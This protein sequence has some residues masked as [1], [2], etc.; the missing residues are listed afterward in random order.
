[1]KGHI[2][3]LDGTILDSIGLWREIDIRYMKQHGIEYRREYSDI[4][5]TLT[6]DECATYFKH[7]LGVPLSEEE[8]K[9]D[10]LD[11][12]YDAYANTLQLKPYAL[13]YV[14]KCAKNGSCILAT[15]CQKKSALAA[16]KRLNL[17]DYFENIVTT[18]DVGKNKEYPDIYLE[19]AKQ[20]DLKPKECL[21]YEDILSALKCAGNA[22]FHVVGVYDEMWENDKQEMQLFADKYIASFKELL[23]E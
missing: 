1:M 2:F 14:Q 5:K 20:L 16:L 4:I 15:S 22:G 21:V 7:V 23:D 19:C 11:M 6:F 13:E 8:I 9:Q 18:E 3:D 17:L 10:W 12:S